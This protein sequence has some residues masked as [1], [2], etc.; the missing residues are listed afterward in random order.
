MKKIV[1]FLFFFSLLASVL[2]SCKNEEKGIGVDIS[3]YTIV[4]PEASNIDFLDFLVLFKRELYKNTGAELSIVT[5][6]SETSAY[7][8]ILGDSNRAESVTALDEID[9]MGEDA[10]IIKN[11]GGKI[12]IC[13]KNED[14]TARAMKVFIINS[15]EIFAKEGYCE[16]GNVNL[17]SFFFENSLTE[18]SIEF[19][20]DLAIPEKKDLIF[21]YETMIELAHNG[22]SN[23][24]LI[25][26]YA[27]L[28][29][30]YPG[31]RI[32]KSVDGG[33]TWTQIS[34][35]IDN[36]S[37]ENTN[38][39]IKQDCALQPCLFELPCDMGEFKEGTLFLGA[40][41]RGKDYVTQTQ[42]SAIMLYYSEDV[43]ET[44]TC[45]HTLASGGSATSKTGVWEPFFIYEEESGRV[46]CFYSDESNATGT[47][48]GSKAQEIVY[49]YTTDMKKWSKPTAVISCSDKEN[50]R[51]G[52]CSVTRL[53]N[54]KYYMTYEMVGIAHNPVYAKTTASGRLDD[55]GD[56]SDRGEL[57]ETVDKKTLGSA[58]WC[59]WSASGGEKGVLVVTGHH[60]VNGKSMSGASDMFISFDYGE[61]YIATENPLPYLQI[62]D[63]ERNKCGYSAYLGFSKDGHTLYYM[64]SVNTDETRTQSKVVFARIKI[65]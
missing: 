58:P 57:I 56:P 44:W 24:T 3:D 27:G 34:T 16:K 32:H 36:Y 47:K 49:R 43:G 52:M 30:S 60:M 37:S 23:G 13:G 9:S 5:D 25:A 29:G 8:I 2:L 46:Y 21:S 22:E 48:N 38:R 17:N 28:F 14:A 39:I 61:T 15:E 45:Y 55:W 54:G 1:S 50:M 63:S 42:A 7:E 65:W 41:T 59:A 35:A 10:Y 51:P 53:G 19:T 4:R 33:K 6:E 26:T 40:L 18:F 20:T 31:Y 64:N 62:M 11:E 12:V